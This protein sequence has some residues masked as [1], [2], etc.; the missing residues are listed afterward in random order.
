M[1]APTLGILAA[2]QQ[3]LTAEEMV[4]WA[5]LPVDADALADL[6]QGEWRAFIDVQTDANPQQLRASGQ[7]VY[8]FYHASLLRLMRG[9]TEAEAI[10]GL[11]T[12]GKRFVARL[13]DAKTRAHKQIVAELRGRCDGEWVRLVAD[14][15]GRR[16]LTTHL[17]VT[18]PDEMFRLVAM[19]DAWAKARNRREETYVGYLGDLALAQHRSAGMGWGSRCGARC[20]RASCTAWQAIFRRNCWG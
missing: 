15:Y 1:Y 8:R 18:Q 2:A 12:Q 5:R 10:A 19:D 9:E 6:L 16:Y 14:D 17:S 20:S 13:K 11:D 7:A 3:P 4:T